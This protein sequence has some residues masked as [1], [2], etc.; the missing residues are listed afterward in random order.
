MT[1]NSATS[2]L[3]ANQGRTLKSFIDAG[4]V[5][6]GFLHPEDDST[7]V[8]DYP[9]CYL[10]GIS[11]VYYGYG[12]L[13]VSLGSGELA[14]I[15]RAKNSST[16][17]YKTTTISGSGGGGSYSAGTGISISNN[18]I[19]LKTAST[20]QLGGVKVDGST[21]TISNGVISASGGGGGST[22]SW[23][24]SGSDYV[25]L[26]VNG[27]SKK[28]LTSH[29]DLSGYVT[30]ATTQTITGAKTFTTNPVTIASSSGIK[31]NA[32]SYIDI[33]GARLVYDSGSNSLR[34]TKSS[35]SSTVNFYADGAVS[36]GAAGASSSSDV[37]FTDGDQTI[38]GDKIF[39]ELLQVDGNLVVN[40]SSS[41]NDDVTIGSA[42]MS[43]ASSRLNINKDT[44]FQ[45]ATGQYISISEI[46]SRLVSLGG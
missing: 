24:S 28:L 16:W 29:Q 37:V 22:V 36:A 35:G 4:Y 31:V 33:G 20:S 13:N 39:D 23:G 7:E 3:S 26:S 21:I 45:Y 27:T 41:F 12:N 18:T 1:S 5:F 32:S 30:L 46:V 9:V 11:G 44:R 8:C 19:S 10:S 25:Y 6:K 43:W 15:Y 14:L 40:N 2:A 42:T 17:N 38:S 34:V